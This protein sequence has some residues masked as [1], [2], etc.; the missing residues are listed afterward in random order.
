MEQKCFL[1]LCY[2]AAFINTH[3]CTCS[4][5]TIQSVILYSPRPLANYS[6]LPTFSAGNY[7]TRY[8]TYFWVSLLRNCTF[9]LRR[10]PICWDILKSEV[11]HLKHWQPLKAGIACKFLSARYL[12][13]INEAINNGKLVKKTLWNPSIFFFF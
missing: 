7:S 11:C 1:Y 4:H 3:E 12:A 8:L 13:A 2:V 9:V 10:F 5:L 6:L